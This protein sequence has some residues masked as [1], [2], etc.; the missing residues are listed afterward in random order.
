MTDST[1]VQNSSSTTLYRERQWVPWYWWAMAAGLALL[2]A[3]QFSLNRNFWWFLIPLLVG[4]LLMV[5]VMFWMSKNVLEVVQDPDGSRWLLAGDANLPASVVDRAMVVPESAKQ[6]ALGRQLDPAAF[7][8]SRG[9]VKELAL[10]VLNDPE[11]PTPYW[12]LSS[13]NPGQLLQ[14]FVPEQTMTPN[15]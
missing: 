5:W 15:K 8:V 7:V 1:G 3:F 11:D 9:W 14:A 4:L 12:L 2:I 6:N 10:I 13:K